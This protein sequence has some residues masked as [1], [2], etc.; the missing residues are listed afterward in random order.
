M[1]SG[2]ICE[3]PLM[4]SVAVVLMNG[5]TPMFVYTSGPVVRAGA[6]DDGVPARPAAATTPARLKISRRLGPA[7]DCF[8]RMRMSLTLLYSDYDSAAF[9]AGTL[10]RLPV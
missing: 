4:V 2:S 6:A 1:T 9:S 7:A 3:P 10:L 8:V 5:R